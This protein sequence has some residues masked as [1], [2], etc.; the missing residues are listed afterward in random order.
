[1]V[2]QNLSM[3]CSNKLCKLLGLNCI[4]ETFPS[5]RKF[6]CMDSKINAHKILDSNVGRTK[7]FWDQYIFVRIAFFTSVHLQCPTIQKNY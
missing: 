1:M 4:T 7:P 6:L 5:F 2:S 3:D